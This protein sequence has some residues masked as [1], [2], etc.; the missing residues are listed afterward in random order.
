MYAKAYFYSQVMDNELRMGKQSA[1]DNCDEA[2]KLFKRIRHS[3]GVHC[4]EK[5]RS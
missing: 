3:D 1:D 4:C 5:L 2:K